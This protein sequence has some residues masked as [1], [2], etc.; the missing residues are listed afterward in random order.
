[1]NKRDRGAGAGGR[2]FQYVRRNY[3]LLK[4]TNLT[5]EAGRHAF[6]SPAWKYIYIFLE[7][8]VLHGVCNPILR[9]SKQRVKSF[10]ICYRTWIERL[11]TS[12]NRYNHVDTIF[13]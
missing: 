5:V 8:L 7:G 11:N 9:C 3:K 12:I 13:F 6:I 1:M 10:M 4:G 2:A